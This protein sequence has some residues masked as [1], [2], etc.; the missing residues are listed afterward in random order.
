[1]VCRSW[2]EDFSKYLFSYV[3]DLLHRQILKYKRIYNSY[4]IPY[5]PMSYMFNID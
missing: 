2:K 4:K 1:M 3:C 5:I